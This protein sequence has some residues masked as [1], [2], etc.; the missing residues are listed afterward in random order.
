MLSK[1]IITEHAYLRGGERLG[2]K[3]CSIERLAARAYDQGI[4]ADHCKG[5][6]KRYVLD[7][8]DTENN[9]NTIRIYGDCLYLFADNVLVMLYQLPQ[10]LRRIVRRIVKRE[11]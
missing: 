11:K 6:V 2:L 7:R 8:L 10:E 3:Q 9:V 4:D 1:I 5:P